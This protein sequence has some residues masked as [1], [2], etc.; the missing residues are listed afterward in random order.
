MSK[1]LK[2]LTA[3]QITELKQN[4]LA[5]VAYIGEGVSY[6]ELANADELVTMEELEQEY[7]AVAFSN[8]DFAC[9]AGS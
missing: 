4:Y 7:G 3:E 1:T 6:G 2:Q 9:S 8:D 5:N